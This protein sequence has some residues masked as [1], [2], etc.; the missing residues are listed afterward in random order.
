MQLEN[1]KDIWVVTPEFQEIE[2]EMIMED[3]HNGLLQIILAVIQDGVCILDKDLNII[4]LNPTM[5]HWYPEF[6]IKDKKKCYNVFHGFKEP[7]E[8][9]PTMRALKS[10]KPETEVAMYRN[11]NNTKG[12]QRIYSVPLMDSNGNVVLI[13][14]YVK[15]ITHQRKVEL[16]S[17][18][19]ESENSSLRR[20]LEQKEKEREEMERTIATNMELSIKPILN[21]LDKTVGK[22]SAD[23]IRKQLDTSLK[24]LTQNKSHIFLALTQREMQIARLIKEDY[25][26]KEIADKLIITKKTVDY[27]RAN[28]RKKLNLGPD[29][30][31]RKFLEMN[32]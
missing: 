16:E 22:E 28:I 21:Y 2:H 7:C 26:S 30:S 23:F 19:Y 32:F 4:Y 10:N 25:M 13:I 29:D 11:A 14:E 5:C 6:N 27:H 3:L 1:H 15:D 18:F 31:L 24:S 12:W 8:T 17:E 20:F 9:C